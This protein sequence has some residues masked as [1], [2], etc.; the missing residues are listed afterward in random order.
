MT[1]FISADRANAATLL[2]AEACTT[3]HTLTYA[4][5]PVEDLALQLSFVIAGSSAGAGD[6]LA[7]SGTD[8]RGAVQTES[9][10]VSGGNATYT[11]ANYWA[12][13]DNIDCNGWA[14]G[15]LAVTQPIWGVVWDHG[16]GLYTVTGDLDIGD[17]ATSTFFKEVSSTIIF[18]TTPSFY[19]FKVTD[20][21]TAQFGEIYPGTTSPLNGC[22]VVSNKTDHTTL[23]AVSGTLN[24]YDSRLIKGTGKGFYVNG[25]LNSSFSTFQG[26]YLPT[27]TAN[28][29]FMLENGSTIN[30][31]STCFINWQWL[32]FDVGT[33]A[34][35]ENVYISL[36]K[37]SVYGGTHNVKLTGVSL[38]DD[39]VDQVLLNGT[40]MSFKDPDFILDD[41]DNSNLHKV[42]M[43]SDINIKVTDKDGV[44]ISGATVSGNIGTLVNGSDNNRYR[45][46]TSVAAVYPWTV[47]WP[48]AVGWESY[49]EY[50]DGTTC[51]GINQNEITLDGGSSFVDTTNSSGVISTTEVHTGRYQGS[52]LSYKGMY[53]AAMTLTITCSGYEPLV[54]DHLEW[55]TD[56]RDPASRKNLQFELQ[57]EVVYPA[58]GVVSSGIDYGEGGTQYVGTFVVPVEA[59]VRSGIDYGA[60]GIEFTGIYVA[61]GTSTNR[62]ILVRDKDDNEYKL[63]FVYITL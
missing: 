2:P 38:A 58:V 39:E 16:S 59:D 56:N 62:P 47:T 29:E 28:T 14:D 4:V 45:S 13:I 40:N 10:D 17:G 19:G 53:D 9:I 49:F 37:Y 34:Q 7:V 42:E 21:A 41:V 18:S 27:Q 60:A 57:D 54:V 1:D 31:D 24:F 3:G 22:R 50:Y 46:L 26:N 52:A 6:T 51:P 20:N 30:V 25:T 44:P 23:V 8:W 35:F 15:T 55:S 48:T 63:R 32:D 11:G 5:R 36:G 43:L 12:S 61:S 33:P